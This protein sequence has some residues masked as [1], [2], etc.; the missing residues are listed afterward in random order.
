MIFH[1]SHDYSM[2]IS[3][4]GRGSQKTFLLNRLLKGFDNRIMG[5]KEMILSLR[6]IRDQVTQLD[7]KYRYST[8]IIIDISYVPELNQRHILRFKFGTYRATLIFKRID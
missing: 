8:H 7:F 2:N 1:V 5:L 4:S 3:K 6:H